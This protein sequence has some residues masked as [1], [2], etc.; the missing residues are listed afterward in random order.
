MATKNNNGGNPPKNRSVDNTPKR[1]SVN[2]FEPATARDSL[3]V[4]QSSMDFSK[5]I[6]NPKYKKISSKPVTSDVHRENFENAAN[7]KKLNKSQAI[8]PKDNKSTI[9]TLSPEEYREV[10]DRYKYKQREAS[11]NMLD[12]RLPQMMYDKRIQPQEY[13]TY[14]NID[15]ND[16]MYGDLIEAPMYDPVKTLPKGYDSS[17]QLIPQA[18][19]GKSLGLNGSS[20]N[21]QLDNRAF[22]PPSNQMY[23]AEKTYAGSPFGARSTEYKPMSLTD[24]RILRNSFKDTDTEKINF[25]PP[26]PDLTVPNTLALGGDMQQGN[27]AS[28]LN[29]FNVGGRHEQNPLG[30]IPQGVGANGLPNTVEQ[31]ETKKGDFVYSDRLNVP[32]EHLSQMGIPPKL[33]GKTFADASKIINNQFKDRNDPISLKTKTALLDRLA[34]SQETLKAEQ[35]AKQAQLQQA[36]MTNSEVVPDM[37]NGAVPQG[38]EEFVPQNQQFFGGFGGAS[39]AGGTSGA[40]SAGS[41][42]G[43]SAQGM[44]QLGGMIGNIGSAIGAEGSYGKQQ[45]INE[46]KGFYDA[47]LKKDQ[48]GEEMLGTT[49]DTVASAFGPIGQFWRGIQKAG[50]GIGD[51]IGGEAGSAVSGIFSPEEATFS[52]FTNDDMNVGEKL[53]G[54]VPGLGA[55]M[56]HRSAKKRLEKF[57]D[58]QRKSEFFHSY[59]APTIN[60]DNVQTFA[61]GGDLNGNPY[62]D[63][64]DKF[65]PTIN[66]FT[67]FSSAPN[68][69]SANLYHGRAPVTAVVGN[70][71]DV[72]PTPNQI[73]TRLHPTRTPVTPVIGEAQGVDLQNPSLQIINTEPQAYKKPNQFFNK[74]K[75]GLGTIGDKMNN[76]DLSKLRYAPIG[77]NLMQLA[78]MS[79]PEVERLDRL[80]NQY[81]KQYLDEATYENQARE[82]IAG[83]L[84]AIGRSGVTNGQMI[85][86]TLA[87]QLNGTRAVAEGYNQVRRHN[88]EQEQM[89]QQIAMNNNQANISQSNLEKDI[90]ARNRAAYQTNRSKLIGQLGNDIGN[91]GREELYKDLAVSSTGYDYRGNYKVLNDPNSTPEEKAIAAENIKNAEKYEKFFS[92]RNGITSG[93]KATPPTNINGKGGTMKKLNFKRF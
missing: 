81:Q 7:F 62:P 46:Q 52:N 64:T 77:A 10:N 23:S 12:L 69:T 80:N 38:M 31:G 29:E 15:R 20:N 25:N 89:R 40:G 61:G 76:A 36:V 5:L 57:E 49:K 60:N 33:R 68:Q 88:I 51:K 78:R 93:I 9:K 65:K 17:G 47:K 82:Q 87:A 73:P 4:R 2:K 72:S 18:I 67:G 28:T 59:I 42:S 11:A 70:R 90:N 53:L 56:A 24:A 19:T 63:F 32:E 50:K 41:G 30:G 83:A 91:V 22:F 85:N 84:N 39:G 6:N 74:L 44:G 45:K 13:V 75:T 34:Q 71:Q 26:L 55:V 48:E 8:V 66:S 86:A 54:T 58:D 27:N 79:K 16:P 1:R 14:E 35:Q 3:M 92:N 21:M 43:M 37:M